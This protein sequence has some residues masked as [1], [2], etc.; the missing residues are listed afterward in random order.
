MAHDCRIDVRFFPAPPDFADC[1]T[2]IY[3]VELSVPEGGRVEDWL[4]PEWGN[5]RIF[6]G[7]LPI[8]QI[9][10]QPAVSGARFTVTGPSSLSN[11]F[12]LGSTRMWGIGLLPLGWARLVRRPAIAYA[13]FMADAERHPDFV[14]FAP[15]A[16]VFAD[17]P[18]DEAEFERILAVLRAIDRPVREADLIRAVHGAMVEQGLGEVADFARRGGLSVRSLERICR[19]HFGFPPKRLLRR[20]R[21]MRSLASFMLA[22]GGKWS[23]AID[24]L[25]TDQ[26]HFN[27]ECHDFMGMGPREYAALPHP[28]LTSFMAERA[29]A[30][31]SAAQVLDRPARAAPAT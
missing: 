5:L 16:E 20:Q 9:A 21:F 4:Q 1:F 24:D 25:Y 2:S 27:R 31:G 17:Q 13:N 23:D 15:L 22:G 10:G 11:R 26:A 12:S 6:S 29:R 8:A 30:H 19:R 14:P 7:D 18:G 3:R 28:I